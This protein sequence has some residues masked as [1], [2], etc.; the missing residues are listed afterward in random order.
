MICL[1]IYPSITALGKWGG[2][3]MPIWFTPLTWVPPPLETSDLI[4]VWR[5]TMILYHLPYSL[6]SNVC[7]IYAI[8]KIL[9]VERSLIRLSLLFYSKH[10]CAKEVNWIWV[11]PCNPWKSLP[12]SCWPLCHPIDIGRRPVKRIPTPFNRRKIIGAI[13]Q[14]HLLLKK[15]LFW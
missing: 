9:K 7:L 13:I 12:I 2:Y 14:S 11:Y 8:L 15:K 4:A 5:H 3:F 10:S 6:F 1:T